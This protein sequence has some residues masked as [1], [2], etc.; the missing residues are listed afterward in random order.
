MPPRK[1]VR[2]YETDQDIAAG[3]QASEEG[4][5]REVMSRFGASVLG[6]ASRVCC[7]PGLAQ[8]A[9]QDAFLVLWRR[10]DVYEPSRGG[11]KTLLVSI[12]RNK[13]IDLVRREEAARRVQNP[14]M[15]SLVETDERCPW[16]ELDRRAEM[17]WALGRLTTVQRE[18]ISLAY[19]GGKTYREVA[20]GLG[21]AEGTAKTRIRDGLIRLRRL[22]LEPRI[23]S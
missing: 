23:A 13:A 5:L 2:L 4:A 17:E 8:E 11:L 1:T 20:E 18:A 22:L 14:L 10:P 9:A 21:I 6:I 3:L 12:A 16:S 7:D 15:A 19:L